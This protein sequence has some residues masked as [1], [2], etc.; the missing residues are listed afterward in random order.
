[1][2]NKN[3][4]KYFIILVAFL[5]VLG[6]SFNSVVANTPQEIS[7]EQLEVLIDHL[8][9]SSILTLA[10]AHE[11][12]EDN[13]L[14]QI[15]PVES[16]LLGVFV[17]GDYSDAINQEWIYFSTF[18]IDEM[19]PLERM[20][21]LD[22][23][24][25]NPET[26]FFADSLSNHEYD[27]W[28][29]FKVVGRGNLRNPFAEFYTDA[30]IYFFFDAHR[31]ICVSVYERNIEEIDLLEDIVEVA[32]TSFKEIDFSSRLTV[33]VTVSDV[34]DDTN[35]KLPVQIIW[36]KGDY[37]GEVAG[38]YSLKGEIDILCDNIV[39]LEEKLA[40]IDVIVVPAEPDSIEILGLN[41]IIIPALHQRATTI[42]YHGNILDKFN[43]IR[44]G[45]IHWHLED[46]PVGV[47][48][49]D[50]YVSVD[51]TA[52]ETTF[53]LV[54]THFWEQETQGKKAIDLVRADS[55]VFSVEI[56]QGSQRLYIPGLEEKTTEEYQAVVFDQY[57]LAM[58]AEDV[59]WEL[60]ETKKGISI[61]E[62]GQ[63]TITDEAIAQ[64]EIGI[65]IIAKSHADSE[66]VDKLDINLFFAESKVRS[67]EILGPEIVY[68]PGKAES[69]NRDYYQAV[70]Y[71]QYDVKMPAETVR[72]RL[73]ETVDGVYVGTLGTVYTNFNAFNQEGFVV[74]AIS[75]TDP[76]VIQAKEV[77]LQL[78]ESKV[79]TIIA[80][81]DSM[82][83]IPGL[84]EDAIQTQYTAEVYDQY[85]VEM[86]DV[87]IEWS[88]INQD[89]NLQGVE[90]D[91]KTGLLTVTDQALFEGQGIA[92]AFDVFVEYEEVFDVISGVDLSLFDP[93]PTWIDIIGPKSLIIPSKW[94]KFKIVNYQAN[95]YDQ[96][97]NLVQDAPLKWELENMSSLITESS[98][99]LAAPD[100]GEL[101]V[102]MDALNVNEDALN[103][104][105]NNAFDIVVTYQSIEG[106]IKEVDLI[107]APMIFE[108]KIQ[109]ARETVKRPDAAFFV[110]LSVG[111]EEVLDQYQ[112]PLPHEFV[113]FLSIYSDLEGTLIERERKFIGGQ[114]IEEIK[115][116]NVGLHSLTAIVEDGKT[117]SVLEVEVR[118]E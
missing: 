92:N 86:L 43:N 5:I 8:K 107:L 39:N 14:E 18:R 102:T 16:K 106:R 81:G 56:V 31:A 100:H 70:V 41:Q 44:D 108:L 4:S 28:N 55:Q 53:Y 37:D 93:I 46:E 17:S 23:L 2:A 117:E 75:H 36:Q 54:G 1:M 26:S 34:L 80:H 13:E 79:T 22:F 52:I 72:W 112:N 98:V 48:V 30:D 66:V 76:N 60:V 15:Y 91:S 29:Y 49:D 94:D 19:G 109:L 20:E 50:G 40:E 87:A 42:G 78:A 88:L 89:Q 24:K 59:S 69:F 27:Q 9:D 10:K 74:M 38:T 85:A 77:D 33:D 12:A 68:I 90:I 67:I 65:T 63:L 82:V 115:L 73:K 114:L 84:G 71:D 95:L 45:E 113:R 32:G 7:Q 101:I 111:G 25:D 61:C 96:Y 62:E 104:G 51:N 99:L 83:N 103:T 58:P 47:W 64:G 21:L 6:A 11:K 57:G 105:I 116:N 35:R 3:V 110:E 118:N 97:N